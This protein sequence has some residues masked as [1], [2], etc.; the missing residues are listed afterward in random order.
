MYIDCAFKKKKKK[1]TKGE[2]QN[3]RRSK[4]VVDMVQ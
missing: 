3:K 2:G 4:L 1:H